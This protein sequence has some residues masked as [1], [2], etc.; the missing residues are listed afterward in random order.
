M[1]SPVL[2]SKQLKEELVKKKFFYYTV[3]NGDTLKSIA[4]EI[5]KDEGK[6]KELYLLNESQLIGEEVIEGQKLRYS[7]GNN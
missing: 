1:D 7:I 5:Y 3:K 2:V 6:W 4:L